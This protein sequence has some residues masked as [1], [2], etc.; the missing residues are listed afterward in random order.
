MTE[1]SGSKVLLGYD[2]S[3]PAG[4]AIEV[5]AR[6]LPGARASVAYVWAPPFASEPL[7]RRLWHGTSG[8]NEFVAAIEHQGEAEAKRL[9]DMGVSLAGAHGWQAQAL[10]RRTYGGE[11][12]QL[13]EIAEEIGADLIVLGSRGLGG[14]RAVLGSVS[15]V[16]VHYASRPVLVIPHPLLET[17]RAMLDT[18]PVVLG[19]DGSAGAE[20]A[21]RSVS[22]L[23]PQRT[24]VPVFVEDGGGPEGPDI[25]GLIK[26]P[27]ADGHLEHGRGTAAALADQARASRAA[28]IA[29]GS[30]GRS[31]VREILLGSVAM[32]TLHHVFRPVLVVPHRGPMALPTQVLRP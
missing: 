11:G 20:A 18:G 27:R 15:D 17:E 22:E 24:V 6:L 21:R 4:A 5:A 8:I 13:G 23:F 10:I 14:A 30:R 25:T 26:M 28:L 1:V 7:R 16:A 2:G 31:A 3:L 9:A 32:A 19:W 12:L 29:V